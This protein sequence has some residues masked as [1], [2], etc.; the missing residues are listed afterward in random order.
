M[1]ERFSDLSTRKSQVKFL[2]IDYD[3]EALDLD[4]M[5]SYVGGVSDTE[6]DQVVTL[7]QKLAAMETEMNKFMELEAKRREA[8]MTQFQ[9]RVEASIDEEKTEANKKFATMDTS[10]SLKI[11]EVFNS[12]V[13]QAVDLKTQLAAMETKTER[14]TDDLQRNLDQKF[15]NLKS[16][17]KT[18]TGWFYHF[19][20]A[21]GGWGC[22]GIT[23]RNIIIFLSQR[24]PFNLLG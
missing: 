24:S 1:S 2:S 18:L 5:R 12:T 9:K 8:D 19:D 14:K 4:A 3:L 10:V 16:S 7:T 21:K 17:V 11:E 23:S 20:M 15:T 13:Q 22:L 6:G